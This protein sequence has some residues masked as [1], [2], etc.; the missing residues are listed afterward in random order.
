MTPKILVFAGSTRK[1][2]L[3]VKLAETLVAALEKKGAEV[4]HL[5]LEDYDLPVYNADIEMPDHANE[6]ARLF[7]DHDGLTLVSP[8]YNASLTPLMK[9]TLDWVSVTSNPD[10]ESFGPYKAKPCFLAACSPGST[11][12]LRGLYHL[13]AVLMNVGAEILTSQLA[14]PNGGSAFAEEAGVLTNDRVNAIMHAGLDDLILAA[15]RA[16]AV[17]A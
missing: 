13:R 14:V 10:D 9:N 2:S 17:P 12:G 4:T 16:K 7:S 6:L 11:G 5:H 8:E 1:G 3:N 15:K